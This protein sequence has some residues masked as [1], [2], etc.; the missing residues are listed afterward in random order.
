MASPGRYT[1]G[2]FEAATELYWEAFVGHPSVSVYR[3]LVE[4]ESAEDWLARCRGALEDALV[5]LPE[6]DPA[7]RV[8]RAAFGPLPAPVPAAA[9]QQQVGALA[10]DTR[11]SL[12][13]DI[14]SESMSHPCVIVWPCL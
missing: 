8:P 12:L 1:R 2:G 9:A 4:E 7:A 5:R 11:P 3:R 13:I 6:S 14:H 10:G